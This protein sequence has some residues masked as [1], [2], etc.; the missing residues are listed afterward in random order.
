M[1]VLYKYCTG[2]SSTP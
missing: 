1:T 2:R